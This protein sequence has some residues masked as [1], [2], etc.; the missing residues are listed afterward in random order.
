MSTIF[1][2]KDKY[3]GVSDAFTA[4]FTD[5]KTGWEQEADKTQSADGKKKEVI[6]RGVKPFQVDVT[7]EYV[8]PYCGN[9]RTCYTSWSP[10][11]GQ[12]DY[13]YLNDEAGDVGDFGPPVQLQKCELSDLVID[14]FGRWL[15]CKTNLKFVEYNEATAAIKADMTE[16]NK[17]R[18]GGERRTEVKRILNL[19]EQGAYR[20]ERVTFSVGSTVQIT[21]KRWAT[22]ALVPDAMLGMRAKIKQL[23]NSGIRMLVEF[24]DG[25]QQWC[26]NTGM[27]LCAG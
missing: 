18:P 19:G 24:P 14:D 8:Y 22:G 25:T 17:Y 16:V 21:G 5:F 2:W 10:Y 3:L 26:L 23:D 4:T 7:I 20:G 15:K 1:A 11:I 27:S 9:V 13:I 6:E 12:V